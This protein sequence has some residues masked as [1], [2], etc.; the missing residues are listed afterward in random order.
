MGVIQL[1]KDDE[2][3]Q[4]YVCRRDF[5]EAARA[6]NVHINV[7]TR[8]AP[9]HIPCFSDSMSSMPILEFSRKTSISSGSMRSCLKQRPSGFAPM[10]R[11]ERGLAGDAGRCLSA[12]T[13]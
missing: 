12:S 6:C 2:V 8:T 3:K 10:K 7:T 13:R 11:E 1:V 9:A 4:S 5:S